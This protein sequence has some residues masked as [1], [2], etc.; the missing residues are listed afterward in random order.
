M[1]FSEMSSLFLMALL[2]AA[3]AI[4]PTNPFCG[5]YSERNTV[6]LDLVCVNG[7]IDSV[8]AFF[9]TPSGCPAPAAGAC[10]DPAFQAYAQATCVG[11]PNCTL[12]S[13]GADPCSGVVKAIAATA[14]CSLPPGG[15]APTPPPPPPSPTCSK[16]GV[17][18]PPPTWTPTWNL[19]KSTV[20]QP[21]GGRVTSPPPACVRARARWSLTIARPASL[22]LLR[23]L[24]GGRSDQWSC[25]AAPRN[26][27]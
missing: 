24:G 3:S 25:F 12:V 1:S 21:G 17:P 6:T 23:P 15:F 13:Q 27:R 16:N 7:V 26:L 19:T 8:T 20:I 4:T 11:Q 22:A 9:G 5:Y 18:C 2:A 14:H 10:D